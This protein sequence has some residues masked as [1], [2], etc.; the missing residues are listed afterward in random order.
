MWLTV[1]LCLPCDGLVTPPGCILA[2]HIVNWYWLL[3]PTTLN[4]IECTS[5]TYG[6]M[7]E[8]MNFS[9]YE[10]LSSIDCLMTNRDVQPPSSTRTHDDVQKSLHDSFLWNTQIYEKHKYK[11]HSL[12]RLR[13]VSHL[14]PLFSAV[15]L[16]FPFSTDWDYVFPYPH[17]HN[18]QT[19]KHATR[20]A[21]LH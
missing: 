4:R 20:L 17:R 14:I 3:C 7:D 13:L 8:R 2:S 18:T 15:V 9:L 6:W 12:Q 1:S 16:H 21:I 5:W 11:P 10:S 19:W